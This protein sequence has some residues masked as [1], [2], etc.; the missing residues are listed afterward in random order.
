MEK[1]S[2]EYALMSQGGDICSAVG[3]CGLMHVSDSRPAI[4]GKML[5]SLSL[6]CIMLLLTSSVGPP[7]PLLHLSLLS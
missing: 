4:R 5:M 2:N 3:L 1:L 7:F 6:I